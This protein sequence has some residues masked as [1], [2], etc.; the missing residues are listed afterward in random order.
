MSHSL[1][2][3]RVIAAIFVGAAFVACGEATAP[4][5]ERTIALES[6]R[7][8]ADV[9]PPASFDIEGEFWRGACDAIY[10]R[11]E[12]EPAGVRVSV[13]EKLREPGRDIVCTAQV[14]LDTVVVRVEAP[15]QLPFTVRVK[16]DGASDTVFVI[17]R[18]D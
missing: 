12:R 7:V 9:V 18:R 2:V 14:F 8:P 3:P 1:S 13:Y 16:R 15:Y 17:R 4:A 11:V 10:Q 5:R 6:V